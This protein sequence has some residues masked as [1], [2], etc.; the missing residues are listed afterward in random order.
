[1]MNDQF[2]H[3]IP[4]EEMSDSLRELLSPEQPVKKASAEGK[5][6][7][8]RQ[9]MWTF[10]E[11]LRN[12]DTNTSRIYLHRKGAFFRMYN[13]SAFLFV[14]HY[15]EFKVSCR[16]VKKF[17]RVLCSVGVPASYVKRHFHAEKIAEL[18]GGSVLCVMTGYLVNEVEYQLWEE[19]QQVSLQHSERY[20]RM[21]R[22]I[23]SQD[24]YKTCWDLL[25]DVI[26]I[27]SNAD[28]RLDIISGD[29]LMN[30]Y[31]L[32]KGVRDFYD[33]QDRAAAA[34]QLRKLAD[35]VCFALYVLNAKR[36]C[37]D[38]KFSTCSERAESVKDQLSKLV[39]PSTRTG[40]PAAPSPA[41]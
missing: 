8:A 27:R 9:S 36:Q 2:S 20:T 39:K 22:L 4:G 40:A 35:E 31:T 10:E 37:S 11:I 14:R 29:A 33:M 1:M 30:A 7:S 5:G 34:N 23:E 3:N 19:A 21:T 32:T 41:K 24:V 12:E 25:M 28:R 38:D 16:L 18:E 13:Q 26:D 6:V 15:K 17:G